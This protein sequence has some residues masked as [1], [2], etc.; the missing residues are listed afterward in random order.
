MVG[1]ANLLAYLGNFMLVVAFAR[2]T[3][4]WDWAYASRLVG[5]CLGPLAYMAL[6]CGLCRPLEQLWVARGI[7]TWAR[8]LHLVALTAASL[9][10][11]LITLTWAPWRMPVPV[12]GSDG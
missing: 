1:W 6:V 7:F 12:G 2:R 11:V 8:L 10:L 9:P 5:A 3:M 4:D